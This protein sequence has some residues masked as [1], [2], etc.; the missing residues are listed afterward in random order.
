MNYE[1]LY[2]ETF[3]N[4]IEKHR[5]KK[6]RIESL[7]KKILQNPFHKSHLLKKIK[8]IDLRGKRRRHLTS[9]FVVVYT[10]CEEC[11]NSNLH[12]YNNCINCNKKPKKQVIFIAFDCYDDIYSK[13]YKV[14]LD[15]KSTPF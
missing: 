8:G 15:K 7:V 6:K 3:N 14:K 4:C 10:I 2:T 11:I 9:N 13:E 12:Q 5:D 1:R